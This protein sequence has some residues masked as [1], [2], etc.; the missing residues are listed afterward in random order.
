MSE[1]NTE[2]SWVPLLC[3]SVAVLLWWISYSQS[4]KA[5]RVRRWYNTKVRRAVSRRV[6]CHVTSH[7]MVLKLFALHSIG[8]YI[9]MRENMACQIGL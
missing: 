9:I 7:R 4:T 2:G 6:V 1:D 5:L 3:F 8:I